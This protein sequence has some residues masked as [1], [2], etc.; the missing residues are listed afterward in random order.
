MIENMRDNIRKLWDQYR[1]LNIQ[2]IKVKG[3]ESRNSRE[4][5]IITGTTEP[6]MVMHAITP[7]LEKLRQPRLCMEI[8][9]EKKK[10]F[11]RIRNLR[12]Q[13]ESSH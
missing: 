11:F 10:E 13:M 3:R 7:A 5:F 12:I 8:L 6:G 2:I 9:S 1:R 4:E